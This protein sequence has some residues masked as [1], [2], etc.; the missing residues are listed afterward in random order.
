MIGGRW[1]DLFALAGA[2]AIGGAAY[3]AMVLALRRR[4][5]LGRLSLR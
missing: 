4:L 1:H 2:G 3:G 5:P